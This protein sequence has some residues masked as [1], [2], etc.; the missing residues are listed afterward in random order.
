MGREGRWV[1]LRRGGE[2]GGHGGGCSGSSGKPCPAEP[3]PQRTS[4]LSVPRSL[5]STSL[6]SALRPCSMRELGV[7]GSTKEPMRST[8]AGTAARPR[9]RRQ[10]QEISEVP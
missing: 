6:P 3:H 4:T 1:R 8:V 9:L 2:A 7:S 5:A 10:P